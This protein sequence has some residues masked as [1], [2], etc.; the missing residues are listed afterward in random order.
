MA[1]GMGF[2]LHQLASIPALELDFRYLKNM[3]IAGGHLR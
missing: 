2:A 1:K 3:I